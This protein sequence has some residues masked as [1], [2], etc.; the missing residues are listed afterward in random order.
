MNPDHSFFLPAQ[1]STLAPGVD[2]LFNFMNWMSLVLFLLIVGAAGYFVWK[3]RRKP[4]DEQ[5]LST[6]T[7]HSVSLELFWSVGPLLAC[8]GL[9]HWGVKQYMFARVAPGDSIEVRVRAHKWAWE[10]E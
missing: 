8:F 6:P 10:F 4:G 9:F 1:R 3:F 5:K 2:E 7:F